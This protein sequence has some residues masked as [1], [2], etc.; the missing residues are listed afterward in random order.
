MCNSA[1]KQL[2]V[3]FLKWKDIPPPILED[4]LNLPQTWRDLM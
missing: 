4:Q 2:K 3:E 1:G